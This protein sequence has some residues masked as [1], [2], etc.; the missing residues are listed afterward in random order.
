MSFASRSIRP[1]LLLTHTAKDLMQPLSHL[2]RRRPLR[3]DGD[4]EIGP[5]ATRV[6]QGEILGRPSVVSEIGGSRDGAGNVGDIVVDRDRG[7]AASWTVVDRL[8]RSV[9]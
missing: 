8:L 5:R 4:I 1:R 7:A 3:G 2:P 9:L 6:G